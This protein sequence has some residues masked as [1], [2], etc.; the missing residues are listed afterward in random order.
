M[1]E[2]LYYADAYQ[3]EFDAT[4]EAVELRDGLNVAV[5]DR[6]SFYPTSGGQPHDTGTLAGLKVVDVEDR[7]DGAIGHLVEGDLRVGQPVHGRV[8]WARRFDHMQQHTGQHLLSAAFD[9]LYQARTVS[10]HL[11][12]LGSTVDL[13]RDLA[14]E[15]IAHA[16][17][18]ANRVV[19]E[20]RVVRITSVGAAAAA[21]LPLRK[22]STREGTLRLVEVDGFDLSACGGTHVA[23]TGGV[24]IIGVRSWERF[25]GGV[26]VEFV[27]GVRALGAFRTA[28][29]AVTQSVGLL[30]AL[31]G[32]LPDA[33][34]RLQEDQRE[35]KRRMATLLGR[36]AAHEA[37]ALAARGTRIGHVVRVLEAV[38][39][40]DA[41]GLKSLAA[42][43]TASPGHVVVLASATGPLRL[44]VARSEDL[45]V[46]AAAVL[47][48]LVDRFGG[49]GG[50]RPRLAQAG[51]LETTRE[52]LFAAA[53]EALDELA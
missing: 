46:D 3:S 9:H 50:G 19:W 52:A 25:K 45:A 38:E 21:A 23:R 41:A 34:G 1:T 39:D 4:V 29:D 13:A 16:E 6:T 51:G 14:T 28:R 17:T 20:D 30:S 11:G 43:V 31:P 33:I 35:L 42:A 53:R 48:R 27:C 7:A 49:R 40:H 5:L 12:R 47:R 18:E 15:A 22:E 32:D 26:R 36:L 8:D 10:F 24:G 37:A 44:V 2:R